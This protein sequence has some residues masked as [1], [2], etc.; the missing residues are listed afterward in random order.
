MRGFT[1]FAHAQRFFHAHG[2]IQKLFRVGRH[3][4]RT[5]HHRMLRARSFTVWAA[6]TT[7]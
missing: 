6:V 3:R 4:L 2:V 1:S 7:A 5:V